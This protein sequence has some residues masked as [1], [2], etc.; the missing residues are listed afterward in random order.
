MALTRRAKTTET[1]RHGDGTENRGLDASL[2]RR[3]V[4]ADEEFE[5]LPLSRRY[6]SAWKEEQALS[7]K[8]GPGGPVR[9]DGGTA[10]LL[11]EPL[12]QQKKLR[13]SSVS[14]CLRGSPFLARAADH[15]GIAAS[16]TL[17]RMCDGKPTSR[18]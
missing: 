3:D 8:P 5:W 16:P 1:L 18:A 6:D 12:A 10:D 2:E 11:G 17:S 4:D 14:Q 9:S 7:H 15:P 13:P